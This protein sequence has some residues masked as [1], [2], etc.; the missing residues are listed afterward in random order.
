VKFSHPLPAISFQLHDVH[1]ELLEA[2]G[3]KLAAPMEVA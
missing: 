3:W 1:R 2:G